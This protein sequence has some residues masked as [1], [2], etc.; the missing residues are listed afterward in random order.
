MHLQQSLLLSH[1]H[2]LG[3]ASN[4]SNEIRA[5]CARC[6]PRKPLL[7]AVQTDVFSESILSSSTPGHLGLTCRPRAK[8]ARTSGSASS[9]YAPREVRNEAPPP[10]LNVRMVLPGEVFADP[11][12]TAI[13]SELLKS[14]AT[15]LHDS[16]SL[17]RSQLREN[18]LT[19][20]LQAI[21]AAV[22]VRWYDVSGVAAGDRG[23]V[24]TR[25][26]TYY[27]TDL[28]KMMIRAANTGA[29]P[30]RS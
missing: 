19:R 26:P 28:T 13:S 29:A 21:T 23:I 7:P 17:V 9:Q 1:R 8:A 12:N 3:K 30:E 6:R 25:K 18:S 16:Q 5:C 11:D 15:A 27:S 14:R 24:H 22:R 4:E 2:G 20:W 10:D